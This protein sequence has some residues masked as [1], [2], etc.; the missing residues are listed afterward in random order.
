MSD[1]SASPSDPIFWMHHSFIDHSYRIWQNMDSS[2]ITTIDG[3]DHFGNPLTLS[4]MVM[5]GGLGPDVPIS[6]IINTMGG[7]VINGRPFCYKY[8][9]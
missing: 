2:R 7:V 1:V 9:Y 6:S 5:L 4:T 3:D 8:N